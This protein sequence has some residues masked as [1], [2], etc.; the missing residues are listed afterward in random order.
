MEVNQLDVF[1]FLSL[2]QRTPLHIAAR[3]GCAN[4][5]EIL[6][7]NHAEKNIQDKDGVSVLL[8]STCRIAV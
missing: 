6:V 7:T 1:L 5:V 3:H 4:V 2:Y 8:K